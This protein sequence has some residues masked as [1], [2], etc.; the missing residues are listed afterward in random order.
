MTVP[1]NFTPPPDKTTLPRVVS[2]SGGRSSGMMTRN[3]I[4][5]GQLSRERGDVI[6]FTN[7]SAEHIETYNFILKLADDIASSKIPLF[8]LEFSLMT[9][10]AQRG[11]PR[12]VEVA[13]YRLREPYISKH[14]NDNGMRWH[15]EVYE[16]M[17]KWIKTVPCWHQRICTRELKVKPVRAFLRDHWGVELGRG[18]QEFIDYLGFRY[19]EPARVYK[20]SA[21]YNGSVEKRGYE[22]EWVD[23][24]LWHL[25]INEIEVQDYW[26][27]QEFDLNLPYGAP[28]SNC[29]FCFLKGTAK[30][31]AVHHLLGNQYPNTPMDIKWWE[32]MEQTY[33]RPISKTALHNEK[34]TTLLP[35]EDYKIGFFGV[36]DNLSYKHLAAGLGDEETESSDCRCSD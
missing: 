21:D 13:H 29:V 26:E 30:L 7:T 8:I 18:K 27:R 19:D 20:V 15:G 4:R 22:G 16:K 28:L 2:F 17:L 10:P 12:D 11:E 3:L 35:F 31:K 36:T 24:P 14:P 32:R 5:T 33:G 34:Q 9:R 6:V 23:F 25:G 1:M